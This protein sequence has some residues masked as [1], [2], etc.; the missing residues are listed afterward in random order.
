MRALPP[1]LHNVQKRFADSFSKSI[2]KIGV[3]IIA[4]SLLAANFSRLDRE[5]QRLNQSGAEW[6]HLDIMDGHFVPNLSFGPG[7]LKS[8]RPLTQLHVD[9]HL[10]CSRPEIL[11]ESFAKAGADSITIHAELGD[12]VDS[13]IGQI[14]SQK[15]KTGLAINPKT[16]I[17]KAI[18][19][20]DS[21][22]LLLIMSVNPGFGGQ[23]FLPEVLPKIK[24]AARFRKEKG[25]T[26]RIQVD[27]GIDLTNA[28]PC[29]RSGA[30]IFV[31]GSSLFQNA[32][33]KSAVSELRAACFVD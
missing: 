3:P 8:I 11:I 20:L 25:L 7:T 15:I 16:E 17:E 28:D 29:A 6:I 21:V 30:D 23:R 24:T 27:G 18:P 13:L 32:N 4:P 33:L 1:P 31:A 26:F 2:H 14:H 9:V 22:D 5:I 12:C 10:M 19:Y